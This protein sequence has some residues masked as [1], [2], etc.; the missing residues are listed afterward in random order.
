M[1]KQ[2]KCIYNECNKKLKLTDFPCRCNKLFCC[3][4]RLPENHKCDYNFK[5]NGKNK[6]RLDNPICSGEKIIKI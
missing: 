3:I 2:N 4:H 6:L 1:D 5:E